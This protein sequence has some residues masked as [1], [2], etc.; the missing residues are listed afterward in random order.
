M[1]KHEFDHLNVTAEQ[2]P[3]LF[4]LAIFFLC[5]CPAP[6]GDDGAFEILL[7]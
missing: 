6:Q 2:W 4:V 5:M 1:D 7:K 3:C